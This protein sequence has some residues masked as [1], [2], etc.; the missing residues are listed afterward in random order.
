MHLPAAVVLRYVLWAKA[1]P[2]R[3]DAKVQIRLQAQ[4][5][6]R[7]EIGMDDRV[8]AATAAVAAYWRR[9]QR[10]KISVSWHSFWGLLH[11]EDAIVSREHICSFCNVRRTAVITSSG[12]I[13]WCWRLLAQYCLHGPLRP[14]SCIRGLVQVRND[15][16]LC[17]VPRHGCK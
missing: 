15:Q 14:S 13:M 16:I 6:C 9:K 12:Q 4:T 2:G 17:A 1:C 10:I 7:L 3:T 8:A 5:L 11:V